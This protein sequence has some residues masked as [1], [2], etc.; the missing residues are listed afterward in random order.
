M[1]IIISALGDIKKYIPDER[2]ITLAGPLTLTELKIQLGIPAAKAVCYS[3]NGRIQKGT[4][5]P[6]ENDHIKFLMLV[7]AG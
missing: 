5:Q 2:P 3:V 6:K 4:Y 7:G 1:H